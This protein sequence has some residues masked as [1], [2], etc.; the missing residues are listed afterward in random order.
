MYT[1]RRGRARFVRDL[2]LFISIN[3]IGARDHGTAQKAYYGRG[4]PAPS[5]LAVGKLVARGPCPRGLNGGGPL[6]AVSERRDS[7]K[8]E[9]KIWDALSP[10]AAVSD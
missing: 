2:C 10:D 5:K 7:N 4:T 8:N 1:Y 6:G 3:Q 9:I